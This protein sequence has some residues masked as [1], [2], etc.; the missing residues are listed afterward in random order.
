M[1]LYK[2]IR[3]ETVM[4]E[5]ENFKLVCQ[6]YVTKI[7]LEAVNSDITLKGKRME[8]FELFLRK[9]EMQKIYSIVKKI[10]N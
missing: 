7:E 8:E 2:K 9:L 3:K 4:K 5:K 1:L 10:E 6:K